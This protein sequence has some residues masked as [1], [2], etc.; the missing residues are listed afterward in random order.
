M[1]SRV[2]VAHI[3]EVEIGKAIVVHVGSRRL[4]LCRP[5]ADEFYAID[6]VC[7]HD[8]GPLGEG[9]LC[10]YEIECPRHGAHFDVRTG[11]ALT[12]PATRPV[13]SYP[14]VVE[15]NEVFVELPE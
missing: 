1:A 3:S 9:E 4:A 10:G 12:L 7:T 2:R 11:E 5:A 13:H 8:G 14:T 15:G 6:D